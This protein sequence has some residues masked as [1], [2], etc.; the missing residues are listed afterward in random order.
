MTVV[1]ADAIESF[2]ERGVR[3]TPV[4]TPFPQIVLV[5]VTTRC[6]LSCIHCPSSQLYESEGFVGD[7]D[8]ELYRKIADEVAEYPNTVFRPFDGGEPLL[9]R[10]IA[11]MIAYAKQ[12]GIR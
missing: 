3:F 10:D 2:R 5:D 4:L 11:G 12:Q 9:R 8:P 7:I 1:T 6:N